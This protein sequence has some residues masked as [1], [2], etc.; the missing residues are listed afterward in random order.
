MKKIL[1][2][3]LLVSIFTLSSGQ[4]KFTDN[5]DGTVY[6]TITIGNISWMAENLKF[7]DGNGAI[8][9]D[10]DINNASGYGVLY[11]WETAR[12]VMSRWL[13]PAFRKRIPDP[14]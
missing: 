6:R 10:N 2:L 3:C 5:R 4:A 7:R 11:E 8:F 12:K 9:F 1:S 14:Y 13:A